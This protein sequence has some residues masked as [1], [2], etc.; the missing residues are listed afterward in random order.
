[1]NL[2]LQYIEGQ[3]NRGSALPMKEHQHH[4]YHGQYDH[5]KE[6]SQDGTQVRSHAS[7]ANYEKLD[8]RQAA[9]SAGLEVELQKLK[10][11]IDDIE[12]TLV[13]LYMEEIE[14]PF[15]KDIL[16][17]HLPL[18]FKI[19]HIK[20]Y[21]GEGDP[22]EHLET[23]R[24]WMDVDY[25]L[26]LTHFLSV[27]QE[28]D[29]SLK[30]YITCLNKETKIASSAAVRAEG[31]DIADRTLIRTIF[32][33]PADEE[34]RGIHQPHDDAL[35]ISII[36]ANRKVYRVLIDNRS[37]ADILYAAAFDKMKIGREKL[38][39]ICTPLISFGGEFF[40]PLGSLELSVTMKEPPH[41]VTKM[42]NFSV[43]EH[44]RLGRPAL[45]IFQAVTSTY[46]LMIKFPAERGVKVLRAYQ[47]E[48]RR[49][50]TTT[51]R[52]RIDKHEN[53]HIILDPREEKSEQRDSLVEELDTV[54]LQQ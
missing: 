47:E 54:Q 41:Q 2:V 45:N 12:K 48:S 3:R 13:G 27:K 14:H 39:P 8:L 28:K 37:S 5:E 6:S 52:G 51:L 19:P 44:P 23:Y 11:R 1:M 31:Q 26:P 29:E 42:I 18:K 49:C 36:L 40:I 38:K 4:Q 24:S 35:V 15:T 9:N 32:G 20:L 21:G 34:A 50:Y 22:T 46:Y 33:G 53:R 10:K 43:V 16:D 17:A 7:H 30:D 25:Q